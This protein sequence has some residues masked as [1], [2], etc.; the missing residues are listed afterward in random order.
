ME[1]LT[2]RWL[3][4]VYFGDLVAEWLWAFQ[5]P[6]RSSLCKQLSGVH[7]HGSKLSTLAL[8]CCMVRL[9]RFLAESTLSWDLQRLALVNLYPAGFTEAHSESN[10]SIFCTSTRSQTMNAHRLWMHA[11]ICPIYWKSRTFRTHSIFV[12]WALWAFVRMK[13]LYSRWPLRILWLALYLSPALYFRT[14]AAAYKI[15]RK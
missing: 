9:C 4:T 14:E 5:Q 13:F 1:S 8:Q 7:V 15:I 6:L 3:S 10:F 12:S 11:C 2:I